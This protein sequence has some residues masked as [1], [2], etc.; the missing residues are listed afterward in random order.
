MS[1]RTV[2]DPT[3]VVGLVDRLAA[4][5]SPRI[6]VL[7]DIILD[8]YVWGEVERISP[9]APVQVL[10][11]ERED[12]RLGGAGNVA[13]N[14]RALGA[15][16]VLA[17][18]RGA[19]PEGAILDDLVRKL[20]ISGAA[21][22]TD[23]ARPTIV[24]TRHL[25]HN[26]QMLR[27]DRE[28]IQPASPADGRA[29]LECLERVR[30]ACLILS[31]Y[32]K[33]ALPAEILAAVIARA[34]A[35]GVAVLVDPKSSDFGRYARATAVTPNRAEFE[36]AAGC[37]AADPG[38]F[39]TAALDLIRRHELEALVVT[40]GPQGICLIAA[41]GREE[42][43]AA[44]ARAVYDVTG[45]GDT[46]IAVLGYALAG[47]L[48]L[49]DG[50]HLANA[51]A[52]VVVGRVGA[53]TVSAVEIR[54]ALLSPDRPE[55]GK[56]RTREEI[57][58]LVATLR[59]A[60]KHI[61]LTNGCFDILHAGHVEYLAY[62]RALGSLLV[63]GVNSDASVQRMNKDGMRPIVPLADRMRVLASLE[64]V[65]LVVPFEEDTPVELVAAIEPDTLVKGED[66][67]E[68][69]VVGRELVEARG[70]R[71]VLAPLR[72]GV[73]TTAIIEKIRGAPA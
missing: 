36:R 47:G 4:I 39:R 55:G 17:G 10:R 19:D 20:A 65:D 41:D 57:G 51:G 22:R 5:G 40:F 67:R 56:I 73:S 54:E 64:A 46:V 62:A 18:L 1:R 11:V 43:V 58:P 25:A 6:L 72:P 42:R 16:V 3:E 61:V 33:G 71:V 26:Q 15:E 8:R 32:G 34:R 28:R 35:L 48:S 53:A 49:V 27:V 29:W 2:V 45:A 12:H 21:I 60:G 9:E 66:W 63:V 30:P 24:K 31:D 69:G 50:I 52:G 23:A 14:L 70:G 37:S 68:R 44:R 38:S 59:A 7:G 13:N